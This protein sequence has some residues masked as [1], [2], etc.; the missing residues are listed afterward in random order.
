MDMSR[1]HPAGVI[2]ANGIT[3]PIFV[4]DTGDWQA[5]FDGR[6]QSYP[7]REKLENRLK[8]LTRQSAVKVEI[9]VVRITPSHDGATLVRATL[10]GIHGANGNVLG[11]LHYGGR[12]GDVKEQFAKSYG[13]SEMWFGGDVTDEQI[14][15]YAALRLAKYEAEKAVRAAEARYEIKDIKKAVQSAVDAASGSDEI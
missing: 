12:R 3:V 5:E 8:V 15:E 13:S 7:T 2:E 4:S 10:T 6:T 1:L 11:T 14:T 9:P